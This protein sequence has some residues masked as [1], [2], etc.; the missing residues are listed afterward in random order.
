MQLTTARLAWMANPRPIPPQAPDPSAPD[1]EALVRELEV[2]REEVALLKARL[3]EAEELADADVLAPVLN[4]RAFLRELKRAI[5]FVG[6]YGGSAA[7]LY[8]DL[9]GFKTVND[10]FG[11]AAGDAALTAVAERLLGHVRE[12]DIV[13]RLGG[14]EFGVILTKTDGAAATQKAQA[15]LAAIASEP[16]CA[17]GAQIRLTA[18]CGIREIGGLSSAEQVLAEADAAMFLQKAGR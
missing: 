5:A 18:S 13:G 7:L 16:V 9:D 2:L 12:A 14:D 1:A 8:F 4:R 17:E 3:A 6:R 10:R 15:L 11:H